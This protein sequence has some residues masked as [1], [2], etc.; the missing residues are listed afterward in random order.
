MQNI[1]ANFKVD[2]LFLGAS[3]EDVGTKPL[4]TVI[5]KRKR[6][7]VEDKQ[8]AA[9]IINHSNV[10]LFR[11]K[12]GKFMCAHCPG[13]FATVVELR[14]HSKQH[15]NNKML[16]FEEKP[17]VINTY[18]LRIDITDLACTICGEA[19]LKFNDF[20]KHL[21]DKHSKSLNPEYSDGVIPYIL[22]G[23]EYRCVHCDLFC[24]SVMTIFAHMN[25]HYK[26]HVCPTCGKGYSN[27]QNLRSHLRIH[28]SGQFRCPKCESIFLTHSAKNSHVSIAHGRKD[29]NRCPICNERFDS[30][31]ARV[32]HLDRVHARKVEYK[33]NVCPA[34]FGCANLRYSHIRRVHLK[35]R[36]NRI[37]K[38]KV[39]EN[40]GKST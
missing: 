10:V 39:I 23:K 20:K 7:L 27:F 9:L 17:A 36:R 31:Y 11:Y 34:V 24:E 14:M 1:A 25:V 29:R 12:R 15:E 18:P 4:T 13:I 37:T 5:W 38:R 26:H 3:K 19:T 35:Q 22:T 2:F 40:T 33:C 32:K 8:N 6:K 30:Y 16:I 21:L 28:E